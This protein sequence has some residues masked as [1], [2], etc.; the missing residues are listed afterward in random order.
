MYEYYMSIFQKQK[1][2]NIFFKYVMIK[3]E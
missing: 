2:Y 3:M 1:V